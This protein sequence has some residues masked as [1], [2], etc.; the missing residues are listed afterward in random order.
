MAVFHRGSDATERGPEGALV[1]GLAGVQP[2]AQVALLGAGE[3][4]HRGSVAGVLLD[5]GQRL[6]HR[7]VQVRRE[8]GALLGA[9]ALG[10]LGGEVGGQ[11]VD[12]RPDDDGQSGDAEHAGECDVAGGADRAAAQR[13]HHEGGD[14][15]G[16]PGEHAG[17]RGPATATEDR[18][19]RVDATGRVDPALALRLVGLAPQ[20]RDARGADDQRP[21]D[22]PG[23][24][25]RLDGDHQAEAQAAER[26]GRSDVGEPAD[27]PRPLAGAG[28][29]LETGCG[30]L[31][32]RVGR[33]HHPEAGV[34]GD[35][36]AAERRHQHERRAHPEHG[37][38]E[39]RRQTTRHPTDERLLRVAV[40]APEHRRCEADALTGL[41]TRRQRVVDWG[42]AHRGSIVTQR[43]RP[44]P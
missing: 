1:G 29:A 19:D 27:A 12:P 10:S 9:H 3:P 2:G 42:G 23:P 38:P 15:E 24:Q 13:E 7:V 30:L 6:Q 31:E 21:E 17:V 18:L 39:V 40:G 22:R 43:G 36:E 8:V 16:E 14:D 11:A 34:H 25:Q 44:S 33:Q 4:R 35:A 32:A 26:D 41:G 20:Q 28:G 37:D 5:Q